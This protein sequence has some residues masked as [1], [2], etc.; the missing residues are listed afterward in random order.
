MRKLILIRHAKSSWELPCKDIERPLQAKGVLRALKVAT[1][2]KTYLPESYAVFSSPAVRAFETA[3]LFLSAWGIPF[4]ICTV[5][6]ALYTFD[7]VQLEEIVKSC[8]NDQ[9]NVI[10]FGHNDAITE[11]VNKFGDVNILN[12]PTA[13]FVEI[14]FESNDWK[15]IKKGKTTAVVFPKQV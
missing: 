15:S 11:F 8:A 7:G 10:L 4:S 14:I 3:K 13:G 1:H 6:P 12:V 2:T 5:V 9:K